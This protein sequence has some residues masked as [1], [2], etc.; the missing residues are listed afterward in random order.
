MCNT[1]EVCDFSIYIENSIFYILSY[2][3][4]RNIRVAD[5]TYVLCQNED[6]SN[7]SRNIFLFLFTRRFRQEVSLQIQQKK[8]FPHKKRLWKYKISYSINIY[9]VK[10]RNEKKILRTRGCSHRENLISHWL[11]SITNQFGLFNFLLHVEPKPTGTKIR[12]DLAFN[13]QCVLCSV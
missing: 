5:E 13:A 12:L 3:N 2:L 11:F 9:S 7:N 1:Q 8:N 4:W 6:H 10:S